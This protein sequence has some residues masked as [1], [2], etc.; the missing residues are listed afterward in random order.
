MYVL[1]DGNWV[2]LDYVRQNFFLNLAVAVVMLVAFGGL[3]H[4]LLYYYGMRKR[5][6]HKPRRWGRWL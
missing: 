2:H 4:F 1:M 6:W 3:L 5:R